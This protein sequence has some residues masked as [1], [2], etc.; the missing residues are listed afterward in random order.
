MNY[1][2]HLYLA[3]DDPESVIGSLMG[4]FVK[5]RIDGT[6]S[7]ALR[8]GI[9][10]H[11]KID[12]FTDANAVFRGSKRR[13]RPEFRRYGG[14]LVD[15]YYDHFLAVNWHRYSDVPLE[16]YSQRVYRILEEHRRNLP[17]RMQRSVSYM[18][19]NDLLLSYR[20]VIGIRRALQGIEGRLKRESRLS[21]A[22]LDLRRNYASLKTDFDRFFPELIGYVRHLEQPQDAAD[23][24][25]RGPLD[26]T[27]D[28]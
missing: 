1:L 5:G 13:L 18:I 19:A 6:L 27:R 12:S 23:G 10:V 2:A 11:R 22:V 14:I 7:G 4:D 15:L 25:P 16:D 26:L 24:E 9:T 28:P 20:D 8:W 21:E 3:D 17:S